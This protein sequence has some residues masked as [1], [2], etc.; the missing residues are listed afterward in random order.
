[1]CYTSWAVRREQVVRLGVKQSLEIWLCQFATCSVTNIGPFDDMTFEFDEHINVFVGP[2][3]SGKSTTLMTLANM[4]T[5][6]FALPGRLC[7]TAPA[8]LHRPHRWARRPA[9][10]ADR[11]PPSRP[12]SSGI[13]G[14]LG[15]HPDHARLQRLRASVAAEHRLSRQWIKC[16][17]GNGQKRHSS[18]RNCCCASRYYPRMP[19]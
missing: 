19:S 17:V 16:R 10:G 15:H 3:S 6:P 13:S 12:G 1:M 5:Y 18:P 8:S 2:N 7:K 11:S 9:T 4:V 14:A